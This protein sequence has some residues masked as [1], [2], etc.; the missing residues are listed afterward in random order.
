MVDTPRFLRKADSDL[1]EEFRKLGQLEQHRFHD[2]DFS[3][4]TGAENFERNRYRNIF[5][6]DDTRVRLQSDNN[7]Y[8]NASWIDVLGRRYIAS[9]GPTELTKGHFWQ[10]IKQNSAR[11][12]VMLTPLIE[13]E[14]VKCAR[15]WPSK[16]GEILKFKEEGEIITVELKETQP[17]DHYVVS[18]LLVDG[19]P[20]YHFY[21]DQWV[22]FGN[23]VIDDAVQKLIIEA[24]STNGGKKS[25]MVVHCS[26]GIGRT[27]TFIALDALM[28]ESESEDVVK[29]GDVVYNLVND[30]R[31]QRPGMVQSIV[32]Y[33]YIHHEMAKFYTN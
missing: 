9:Q 15:Y 29:T 6:W 25:P 2:P 24:N 23:P 16:K 30:M 17:R 19:A 20:V 28:G 18:E 26:A 31:K 32:Q 11:V 22:D 4:R 12:I 10:M 27:G 21:F 1:D 5:P 3:F 8:I 33:K 14:M 7:N 13:R